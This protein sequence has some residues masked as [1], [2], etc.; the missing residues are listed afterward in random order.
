MDTQDTDLI[1]NLSLFHGMSQKHFGALMKAARL[2]N[3]ARGTVLIREGQMPAFL[4]I[5]I[6]GTVELFANHDGKES[7]LDLIEPVATFILAAVIR[8]EM[9]LKSARSFTPTQILMIPAAAV[10]NV[11]SRD[12]AFARSI[13]NELASRYRGIVRSLKNE[14]M[15]SSAERLAAWIRD[16]ERRQGHRGYVEL[17]YGKRLLAST[18]GMTPENLSRTLSLLS[19]HGAGCEGRQITITDRQALAAFARPNPLIDS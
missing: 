19:A 17:K 3:F 4:H 18:L 8:D 14:R 7:T 1:R 12:A 13:V 10:R 11:F 9:Y 15:R 5:V 16:E 6:K 2:E